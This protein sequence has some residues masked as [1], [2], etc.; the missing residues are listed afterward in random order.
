MPA[1]YRQK[2][3]DLRAKHLKDCDASYRLG[4]EAGLKESQ[5][6]QMQQAWQQSNHQHEEQAEDEYDDPV[7]REVNQLK[8][9]FNDLQMHTLVNQERA[10]VSDF[11]A[12]TP[13]LGDAIQ[14]LARIK[15][16]EIML[17]N[18]HVLEAQA[19]DIVRQET[20]KLSLSMTQRGDNPAEKLYSMAKTL[21]YTPKSAAPD[22]VRPKANL[23]AIAKH[24]K[25]G[26]SVSSI[27]AA[28]S[29]ASD[30]VP[31]TQ[32][33]LMRFYDASGRIDWGKFKAAQDKAI[34]ST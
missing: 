22:A 9:G 20:A 4:Y 23:Q 6:Q 14:H 17:S 29:S 32:E 2:Y 28:T 33:G 19:Y 8:Q 16:Q 3:L 5:I 30:S 34:R 13:D 10:L 15:A 31:Y 12:K 27:P 21:G 26:A 24:Q 7:L 25:A 11:E 18:P 1:N